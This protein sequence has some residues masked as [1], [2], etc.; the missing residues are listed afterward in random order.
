VKN[1][2]KREK[3][4]LWNNKKKKMITAASYLCLKP[5]MRNAIA[6]DGLNDI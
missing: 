2:R 5:A 1:E 4:W 3:T 6:M